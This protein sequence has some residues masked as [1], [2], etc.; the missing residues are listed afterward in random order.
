MVYAILTQQQMT[1]KKHTHKNDTTCVCVS[2]RVA[3]LVV[4]R[5]TQQSHTHP[6]V[7]NESNSLDVS[8]KNLSIGKWKSLVL[9][10]NCHHHMVHTRTSKN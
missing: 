3:R 7:T 2:A 1:K 5:G 6:L 8:S 10:P 4:W 9:S